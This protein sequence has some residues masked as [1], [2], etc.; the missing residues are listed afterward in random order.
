MGSFALQTLVANLIGG[1][2]RVVKDGREWLIA[3]ATLI[4]T[5]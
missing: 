1:I 3:P 4:N 5:A 2:R